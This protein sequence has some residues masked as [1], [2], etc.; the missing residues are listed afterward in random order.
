M[1]LGPSEY[2]LVKIFRPL[3]GATWSR[4]VFHLLPGD[5]M[6]QQGPLISPSDTL[7][8]LDNFAAHTAVSLLEMLSP[9]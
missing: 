2:N 8:C 5:A 1:T 3:L 7:T 6:A 4:P 9:Y